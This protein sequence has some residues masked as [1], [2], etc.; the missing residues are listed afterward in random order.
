MLHKL[1]KLCLNI[2]KAATGFGSFLL[3]GYS[4]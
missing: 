1:C 3:H 4:G 2:N